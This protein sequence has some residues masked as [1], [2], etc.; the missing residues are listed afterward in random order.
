MENCSF[1]S[2][3]YAPLQPAGGVSLE[4]NQSK[5]RSRNAAKTKIY[6]YSLLSIGSQAAIALTLPLGSHAMGYGCG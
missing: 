5:D 2:M 1:A 3:Q 6:G 4:S